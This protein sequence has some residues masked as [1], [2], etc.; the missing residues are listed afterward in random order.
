M[1]EQET[2][3]VVHASF[4]AWRA[5]ELMI[6]GFSVREARRLAEA[7]AANGSLVPLHDIRKALRAGC[8]HEVAVRIWL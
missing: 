4:S 8:P 7:R 6:M 2:E 3:N 5:D 1:A